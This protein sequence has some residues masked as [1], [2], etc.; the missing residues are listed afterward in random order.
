MIKTAHEEAVQLHASL[1]KSA[2]QKRVQHPCYAGL[3]VSEAR[4]HKACFQFLISS[5]AD[6][7]PENLQAH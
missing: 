4:T 5:V 1:R 2:T 3:E 6:V 7:Q